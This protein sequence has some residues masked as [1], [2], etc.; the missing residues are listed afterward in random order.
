MH[1]HFLSKSESIIREKDSEQP[2]LL[3]APALGNVLCYRPK[4]YEEIGR[5]AAPSQDTIL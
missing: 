5:R 4:P 1:L 3:P 2:H